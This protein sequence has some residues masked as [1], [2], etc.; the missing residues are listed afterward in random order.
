MDVREE[1]QVDREETAA[2]AAA[3][4]TTV[5]HDA[6]EGGEEKAEGVAERIEDLPAP[7]GAA[8][9]ERM[10][11]AMSADVA[12]ALDPETAAQILS[13]M[14][15]TLAA[16]VIADME[17]PE[18]SMVLEAMDPDDRV[19]ILE[20]IT[21]PLHDQLVNEMAVLEAAETRSLE[22]YPP[23]T[24][25]GIMTP[26]VT[27][28]EESL[29]VQQ[30]IEE[31]RRLSEELE[32]MFYVYVVDRRGHL[33]GVLSMRDLILAKP[34]R[35]LGE[36]MIPNVSALPA[37]MD[38]E[39]VA[40]LF[41]KYGYMAM[42][43]VDARNRLVGIVTVDDVVD[44]LQ[45]EAT[46]D[47]QKMFGA[48]GEERLTSKWQFSF[49]MRVWWL[50]VN[51]ATAFLAASVVGA[52]EDTLKSLTLLA[53][54]MPIVAGMGGNAGA[55]A[56]AV[57]I[58]G[59]AVGKVDR[60]LLRHVLLRELIVGIATGLVVGLITAAVALVWHHSKAG[61][62]PS[63]ALGGVVGVALVINHALAGISGAAIPFIMKKLGFDPAQSATIF[64]TTV[65]DVG[66]FFVLFMLA[67]VCMRWLT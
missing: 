7:D 14:D 26:D 49:R 8:V 50:V 19:D 38:Q 56:M 4:A 33:V 3:A 57:S 11:P 62:G 47:V 10:T 2:A 29:T 25:G 64:A 32:Q 20:H 6:R 39:E 41:D 63:V 15:A 23:D 18:A 46:E 17:V 16:S 59:L 1:D 5:D 55:Q 27:K 22:Q 54:Y 30:A 42:P 61:W 58:R 43:V 28:L 12:E 13:E 9:M 36:I 34:M 60:K 65:T 52:F 53:I 40:R 35:K 21:A 51:L 67:K 45:E 66:G 48:G 24:A 37:T 31:L 44:V